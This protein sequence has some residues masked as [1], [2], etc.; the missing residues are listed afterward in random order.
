MQLDTGSPVSVIT[1]P[2]YERN[3]NSVAEAAWF[4]I[5]THLL[6]G[7]ASSWTTQ[8]SIPPSPV[9]RPPPRW[10]A[11][12]GASLGEELGRGEPWTPASITSTDGARLV[13]ADGP[14]GETIRRHSDQVKPRELEHDQ[15]EAVLRTQ[16]RIKALAAASGEAAA[17]IVQQVTANVPASSRQ[18]LPSDQA[19]RQIVRRKRKADCPHE[20]SAVQELILEGEFRTTLD[21]REFLRRD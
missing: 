14:E 5:E 7:T 13:N 15:G 6:P 1:C 9:D 17:K 12:R 10:V 21:G 3:K 8:C 18:H 4:A 20:P 11:A 2:T 16:E 19:L